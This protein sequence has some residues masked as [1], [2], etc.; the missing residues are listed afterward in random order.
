LNTLAE[1]RGEEGEESWWWARGDKGC[2]EAGKKWREE[3]PWFWR[4]D[5]FD[6]DRWRW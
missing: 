4:V 2:G 3:S 5:E 6:H 1:D